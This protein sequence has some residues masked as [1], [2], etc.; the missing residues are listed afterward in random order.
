ME[1]AGLQ[2]AVTGK[3]KGGAGVE[4]SGVGSGGRLGVGRKLSIKAV[5]SV[6]MQWTSLK[7][8]TCTFWILMMNH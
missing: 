6:T 8:Q 2:V 1:R 7:S 3:C 4:A 5:W